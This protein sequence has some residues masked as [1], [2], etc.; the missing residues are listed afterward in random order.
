MRRAGS[1]LGPHLEADAGPQVLR[2]RLT[3]GVGEAAVAVVIELRDEG[4]AGLGGAGP[5]GLAHGGALGVGEAA[6]AVFVEA[7]EEGGAAGG[8]AGADVVDEGLTLGLGEVAGAV[9]VV[10]LED[11]GVAGLAAGLQVIAQGGALQLVDDAVAVLV[12]DEAQ[13]GED[14]AAEMPL[15]REAA[16]EDRAALDVGAQLG[17]LELGE[18]AVAVVVVAGDDPL[19][20]GAGLARTGRVHRVG[21]DVV[22]DHGRAIVIAHVVEGIALVDEGVGGGGAV[23]DVEVGAAFGAAGGEGGEGGGHEGEGERA[24]GG[25]RRGWGLVVGFVGSTRQPGG[26][27]RA[28]CDARHHAG[29]TGIYEAGLFSANMQAVGIFLFGVVRLMGGTRFVY[30]KTADLT[31]RFANTGTMRCVDVGENSATIEFEM[32]K[33]LRCTVAG[34]DYRRGLLATAPLPFGA[35]RHADVEVLGCQARG[36]PRDVFRCRW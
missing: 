36:D 24:H 30:Q 20:Q 1:G 18:H 32:Y 7:L 2:Q 33:D 23:F 35:K 11:A 4:T 25:L 21:G 26:S 29:F 31:P 19:P 10:A 12:V 8:G 13:A 15:G 28:R 5:G 6:I 14:G 17:A 9:F 22:V 3:L 27:K 34:F 16:G